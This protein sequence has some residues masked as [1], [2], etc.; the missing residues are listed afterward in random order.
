[1]TAVLTYTSPAQLETIASRDSSS[2]NGGKCVLA[3]M[4]TLQC[5]RLVLFHPSLWNGIDYAQYVY[6]RCG[7]KS[8]IQVLRARSRVVRS[9]SAV[10]IESQLTLYDS[11][12]RFDAYQFSWKRLC[13]RDS[14]AG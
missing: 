6:H 7:V 3:T 2:S 1:M 8:E 13:V 9:M 5:A 11:Q 12:G 4:E 10:S 14:I